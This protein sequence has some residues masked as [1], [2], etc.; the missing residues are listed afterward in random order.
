MTHI[1]EPAA[2]DDHVPTVP[3]LHQQGLAV[4]LERNKKSVPVLYRLTP[5]GQDE[6]YQV[7]A[8]NAS[9]RKAVA[10]GEPLIRHTKVYG[11]L[12][13]KSRDVLAAAVEPLGLRVYGYGDADTSVVASRSLRP[14]PAHPAV[15]QVSRQ[16]S[17]RTLFE[18]AIRWIGDDPELPDDLASALDVVA[19][20]VLV[21]AS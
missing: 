12:R 16:E 14:R 17:D 8:S 18:V 15:L 4:V 21:G 5:E 1:S 7:M 6:V 19:G 10:A 3:E 11:Y 9:A 20:P 13:A 2:G